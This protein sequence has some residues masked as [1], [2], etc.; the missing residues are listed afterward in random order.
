[1]SIFNVTRKTETVQVGDSAVTLTEPSILERMAYGEHF[2]S[3]EDREKIKPA[4]FLRIDLD[5]RI[6]LIADCM[7]YTLP[8]SEKSEIV[9]EIYTLPPECVTALSNAALK[10]AGLWAEPGQDESE[11][12]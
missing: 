1:M 8:D 9:A 5:A 11:K 7:K 12:K 4:E 6:G 10:L 3:I 2:A